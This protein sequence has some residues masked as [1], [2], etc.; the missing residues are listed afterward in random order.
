M[1]QPFGPDAARST[2]LRF[3]SS[4]AL[5]RLRYLAGAL[6]LLAGTLA[7]EALATCVPIAVGAICN[8]AGPASQGN[9]GGANLT[10]ANHINV[11]NGNMRQHEVDL[12][13]LPGVLGLELVR[14]Y[15]SALSAP[16]AANGI[17]GRGWRL[18]YETRLVVSG[19]VLQILEAD[20]TQV[21]FNRDARNPGAGASAD[22]L[23][24]RIDT[25]P[26][27]QGP[28]YV[29]TWARGAAAGRQLSFDAQG[30]LVQIQA[31]TGEFVSLR[32]DG[33]GHLL[34]VT[35]PQ[36]RS[37]RLNYL[38]R[39][40]PDSAGRF[41]GVQSID[42]P[43][44][45]FVYH[46][47]N[48]PLTRGTPATGATAAN[49]VQVDL[50]THYDPKPLYTGAGRGVTTS[51]IS[52]VYHYEDPR[53]PTLLTGISVHGQGSDGQL[54]EQRIG[55][56]GYDEQARAVL[57]VRGRPAASMTGGRPTPG[58]GQAQVTV[59][60]LSTPIPGKPGQVQITNSLGQKTTDTVALISGQYRL[61]ETRG[62]PCSGCAPPDTRYAYDAAGRLVAESR[63]NAQGRPVRTALR[64]LDARGRLIALQQIDDANGRALPP[65]LLERLVYADDGDGPVRIIRPSVVPGKEAVVE[66]AYARFALPGRAPEDGPLL[67]TRITQTGY[68]PRD[69]QGRPL[70]LRDPAQA[71]R[72][73]SLTRATSYAY[74]TINA[75]VLL[76]QID[77]PLPNGPR[78]DPSDS[79]VTQFFYDT[80]GSHVV[81]IV[82]PAGRTV[83]LTYDQ[84]GRVNAVTGADGLVT[85]FTIDP[86]GRPTQC[87][88][89]PPGSDAKNGMQFAYGARGQLT[90]VAIKVGTSITPL[91]R[92]TYD[93][94]GRMLRYASAMGV[95][96]EATYDTEGHVLSSTV[97][98][99]LQTHRETYGYDAS[100]RLITVNDGPGT[101]F[102]RAYNADR[103][104]RTVTDPMGRATRF[105][106]MTRSTQKCLMCVAIAELDK[107][108]STSSAPTADEPF[109]TDHPSSASAGAQAT[110]ARV[111]RNDFDDAVV[112]M[113]PESGTTVNTFD[114][115]GRLVATTNALGQTV[116][117]SRDPAGRLL[118]RMIPASETEPAQV[119]TYTYA[120]PFLT[121]IDDP[122][123]TT[124]YTRD[125]FGRIASRSVLLHVAGAAPVAIATR[126]TYDPNGRLLSQTLPD[127]S[128]LRFVRDGSGK[129]V[130]LERQDGRF[131]P[132]QV[133]ATGLQHGLSGLIRLTYGNGI[134]AR[135]QPSADGVQARVLYSRHG[136]LEPGDAQ[137]RY[138][139][140]AL[141]D[142]NT[143]QHGT[144]RAFNSP[145]SGKQL[146]T[147]EHEPAWA[148]H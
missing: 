124:R 138:G 131:G 147:R 43:V 47:G 108:G 128:T 26:T 67:P 94:A 4:R 37:L 127:G 88:R 49:L 110:H 5:R 27:P 45:R 104:L 122:A 76:S 60:Y 79:D 11:A 9:T 62:A 134:Q 93:G 135:W 28:A 139:Y 80:S 89:A 84:A 30:N 66:I 114:D 81:K 7:Q 96:R 54:M 18:S 50:P 38:D 33:S 130:S 73:T 15:N 22:P 70:D 17:L 120:G 36:G 25:H 20:G 121:A 31:P 87:W 55:T 132:R 75:R 21:I 123:Q 101:T 105:D 148:M 1:A 51:S 74:Q 35:D 85:R 58:T 77:G 141:D 82:R 57:S 125:A 34:E 103:D 12:P 140:D 32:Y 41:A 126:Y 24:G 65:Q 13:T 53:W 83:A 143:A 6:L 68:S 86:Q 111:L 146:Q 116:R 97:R 16:G 142:L 71:A 102:R 52:R 59:R 64:T 112:I 56:Y 90:Q 29:W 40:L 72:T 8:G 100:G 14:H 106:G 113:S 44:G 119:T 46:Y 98:D 137:M 42:T 69:A 109:F 99:G 118:R 3:D 136:G 91:A 10:V 23:D 92:L 61:L 144:S 107:T 2:R 63:L 133:L 145:V 95:L 19:N 115:A 48:P 129:V 117:L 78:N 39:S